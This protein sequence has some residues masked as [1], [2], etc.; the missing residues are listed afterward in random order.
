MLA[1]CCRQV[2]QLP[3]IFKYIL[4][5]FLLFFLNV[6]A[7]LLCLYQDHNWNPSEEI[8]PMS[9]VY[10]HKLNWSIQLSSWAFLFWDYIICLNLTIEPNQHKL[11]GW[12]FDILRVLSWFRT[13]LFKKDISQKNSIY[14]EWQ[15]SIYYKHWATSHMP[16]GNGSPHSP[17]LHWFN[18]NR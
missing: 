6:S 9:Y 18:K 3:L 5:L 7:W 16:F 1:G 8:Y 10:F 11:Y 4:F 2:R 14:E 13:W 15:E 12:V 17:W